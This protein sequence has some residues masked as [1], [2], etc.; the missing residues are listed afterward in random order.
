MKDFLIDRDGDLGISADGDIE[1][2]ESDVQ[3]AQLILATFQ[4]N[5]KQF[6][7]TGAGLPLALEGGMDGEM[8]RNIQMQLEADGLR[9]KDLGMEGENLT[10]TI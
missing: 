3:N 10:I 7:L 9:L 5:W 4:G 1:T 6:P 8:R 2:G